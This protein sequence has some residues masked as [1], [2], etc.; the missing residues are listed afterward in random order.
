[1]IFGIIPALGAPAGLAIL[2]PLIFQ[3]DTA[4]AFALCLG[5]ATG[6]YLSGTIT[7][8]LLNVPG[9]SEH[10]SLCFD[11]H[12]LARQGRAGKALGAAAVTT[13]IAGVMSPV[14]L[15]LLIP[16][17]KQVVLALGPA[18]TLMVIAWGLLTASTLIKGKALKGLS[19]MFFGLLLSTI[20]FSYASS[21][22]RFIFGG[23]LIF[24]EGIPLVPLFIGILAL[25][26]MFKFL[27]SEEKF[28]ALGGRVQSPFQGMLEGIKDTFRSFIILLQG[29]VIGY[30]IG[31]IPGIGGATANLVAYGQAKSLTKRPE[32]F[33]KGNIDGVIA[34]QAAIA[35]VWGGALLPVLTFGIPGSETMAL[36]LGIFIM[37]GLVPGISLFTQHLPLVYF[38]VWLL[39]IGAVIS[40]LFTLILTPIMVKLTRVRLTT[41]VPIVLVLILIG[42]YSLRQSPFDIFLTL[43]LGLLG[44]EMK[45]TGF[46]RAP[47]VIAFVLGSYFENNLA[48]TLNIF[49][50]SFLWVRPI[51]TFMLVMIILTLAYPLLSKVM[52]RSR[53]VEA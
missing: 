32:D 5:G 14:I 21:Y 9:T 34:P 47:F 22:P 43:L 40:T 13:L 19:M 49:G 3:L 26:E 8:V 7:S 51:A 42:V 23:Q 39:I 35:A 38:M 17:L 28:I 31:S 12:P 4:Q 11:G 36:I 16:Y 1:M 29:T 37:K 20:G 18:E 46:P 6:V 2:L 48:L 10:V 24:W 45:N 53:K 30:I 52:R 25:P 15:L 27:I 33:G 41:L 50:L 44:Y